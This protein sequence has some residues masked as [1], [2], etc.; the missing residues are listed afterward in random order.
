MII[1]KNNIYTLTILAKVMKMKRIFDL[2][3]IWHI[4][5]QLHSL[6]GEGVK[7]G[8]KGGGGSL[9][10]KGTYQVVLQ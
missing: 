3:K 8:A 6:K 9:G 7:S 4:V 2:E 1:I 10:Y 5:N